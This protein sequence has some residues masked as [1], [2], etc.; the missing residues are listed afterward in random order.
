MLSNNGLCL[1]IAVQYMLLFLVQFNISDQFQILW[2]Y[3][4]L[5]QPPVFMHSSSR[6][7]HAS[8]VIPLDHVW[9]GISYIYFLRP[10]CNSYINN[11]CY[12]FCH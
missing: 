9:T 7:R 8:H 5:L 2:S 4:L 11:Y 12:Y 1:C 3:T 10:Q 6:L